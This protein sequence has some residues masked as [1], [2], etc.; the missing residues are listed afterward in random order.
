MAGAASGVLCVCHA[1]GQDGQ[2]IHE[3]AVP[4]STPLWTWRSWGEKVLPGVAAV[5]A[6]FFL[7][8][9][10]FA[11]LGLDGIK[12]ENAPPGRVF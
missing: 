1:A 12:Q 10:L 11:A 3:A 4:L 7:L 9:C 8:G 2:A 5:L 6:G